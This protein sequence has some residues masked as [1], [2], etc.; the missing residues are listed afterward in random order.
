MYLDV[1]GVE[2]LGAEV[3][4]LLLNPKVVQKISQKLEFV[5]LQKLFQGTF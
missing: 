2:A 4:V 1:F 5:N 3:G